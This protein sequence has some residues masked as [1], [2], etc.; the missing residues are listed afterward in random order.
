[1]LFSVFGIQE[2]NQDL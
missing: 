2:I 1:M